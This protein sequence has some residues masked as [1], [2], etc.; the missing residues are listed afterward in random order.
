M[1]TDKI[2]VAG[3]TGYLGQYLVKELMT[4]EVNFSAI[5]RNVFKLNT[6]GLPSDQI[7]KAEVTKPDTL[8]GKLKGVHTVISTVGITRQKDGM[9]YMDVDYQANMNLL[10]EAIL[11]GVKKFVYISAING[12]TNRHLKIMEAKEK[13]VDQL[14]ASEIDY[15]IVR[16]NGFYSD[17]KDFLQ[18][19][20]TGRVFLFGDGQF[21]MNPIHGADL[22]KAIVDLLKEEKKEVVIGGPDILTQN[23]IATLALEAFQKRPKVKHIPDWIRTAF[24]KLMRKF[25][26]PSHY[27]PY[28]FFLT[29]MA[30]DNVA[31]RYGVVRLKDFFNQEAD[32]IDSKGIYL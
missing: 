27:G 9:T 28:E 21:K 10:E 1:E 2:L 15:T 16:P 29:M 20:K 14:K 19:A 5:A 17:M 23:E 18:M 11:S 30:Q 6:L 7:I 24:I 12:A 26:S 3:S 22:A 8:Q 31:P 32:K 13:F 4:R 25:M